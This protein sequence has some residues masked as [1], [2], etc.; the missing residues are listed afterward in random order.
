VTE[1]IQTITAQEFC[2]QWLHHPD[3]FVIDV[4][5][6]AEA[7][8]QHLEHSVNLPLDEL[9]NDSLE[10]ALNKLCSCETPRL[11]IL[12]QSGKRAEIAAKKLTGSIAYAP[13]IIEGGITA[14][15]NADQT[16]TTTSNTDKVISLER[17]VRI[18]AGCLVLTGTV[19]GALIN[20]YF[21]LVPA[22]IGAG[23]IYAGMSDNCAMGL[24]LARMPWNR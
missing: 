23:L 13:T 12:C 22:A 3:T 18:A 17:Q 9:T 11:F 5:S 1:S 14:I 16:L 8:Q 19:A 20:P 4:R 21:Y 15:A 6:P 2:S 7:R 24:L 10:S